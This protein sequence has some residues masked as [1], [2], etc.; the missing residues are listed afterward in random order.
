[1][2]SCFITVYQTSFKKVSTVQGKNLLSNS[3]R[4]AAFLEGSRNNFDSWL[5]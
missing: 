3:H 1:M 4:V 2:T 5:P